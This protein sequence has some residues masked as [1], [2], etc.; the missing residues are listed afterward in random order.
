MNKVLHKTEKNYSLLKFLITI[1]S[2]SLIDSPSNF[3]RCGL[4][5]KQMMQAVMHTIPRIPVV[6]QFPYIHGFTKQ[7][8]KMKS[9]IVLNFHIT[10]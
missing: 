2:N 8:N 7:I 1:A 5:R 3:T 6:T 4:F 10:V 9:T